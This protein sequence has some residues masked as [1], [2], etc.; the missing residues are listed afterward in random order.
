[1]SDG[2]SQFTDDELR[3][4][5]A[6]DFSGFT[7]EQLM[8]LRTA[9]ATPSPAIAPVAAPP[10]P[11]DTQR[12]RSMGQGMLFGGYD[13]AEAYLRS[14]IGENQGA[15]LQDVRSKMQAYQ[16]QSPMESLGY[17]A[18][19]GMAIPAA[20]T[21]ATG[22]EAAPVT[23]PVIAGAMPAVKRM[24]GSSA[25]S[26]IMGGTAG[27]LGGEG[28]FIDRASKIP[29][30]VATG[31]LVAPVLTA[32][33]GAT[34]MLG[35]QLLDAARR[36]SGGRGAKIVE[37]EIQRLMDITGKTVDEI[38]SDIASGRIM[39]E[40]STLLSAVRAMYAQG[41]K[42]ATTIAESLGKRPEQLRQTALT[43]MQSRLAKTPDNVLR[44]FKLSD[45]KLAEQENQLYEDA[46]A[47]G[48]VIDAN[49][50]DSITN[51]F[52]RSENSIQTINRVY[53]AETGKR[54]FFNFDKDGNIVFSRAPTIKDAEIIRRGIQASVDEAYTAGIGAAG[55]PLKTAEQTLRQAIDTSAP[56]VGVARA[57]A[58][59]RRSAKD[60]FNEGRTV[61]A[62]SADEVSI[63]FEELSKDPAKLFAFRAGTMDAI[64]NR[65]S[66]GQRKT[67]MAT[68]T[69]PKRKEGDILR[70]VYPQDDLASLMARV[71]NAAASQAAKTKVM[72][73][74][75]TAS[76]LLQEAK[77]GSN[78]SAEEVANV[79]SGNP[80]TMA[81][82]AYKVARKLISNQNQNL[83]DFERDQVARVLVSQ[84]PA[85]V[86]KALM[87]ESGMAM[88]QQQVANLSRFVGRTVP[89][90]VS[91]TAA[92]RMA[93]PQPSQ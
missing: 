64:R 38:V 73:G 16:Q 77:Q 36:I 56:A 67:M 58:S 45:K 78:I 70:T 63:L 59:A 32:A 53:Q 31:A 44:Q 33:V 65:M 84:D 62:K 5:Q 61:F 55:G 57:E 79:I 68:F 66:T 23:G 25:I 51:A 2:L 50:L 39:A 22:G 71:E 13:E 27:F 86:R 28:D 87:D 21:L 40:N 3:K 72:G 1:M 42:A 76:S 41:G 74:S 9:L 93:N 19:G 83:S 46:F 11:A 6:G 52:K 60:A 35:N 75:D 29:T 85:I 69:D 89:Y 49:L 81:S 48:G 7:T 82:S 91:S 47:K 14:L 15:A 17:E 12:L 54:P 20:V 8:V 18:L 34:G 24:L 37:T 92:R 4:A 80:L 90:G 10:A 43:E 26:G 30:G 88:F